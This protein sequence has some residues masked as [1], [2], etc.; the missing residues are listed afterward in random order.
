MVPLLRLHGGDKSGATN[1]LSLLPSHEHL[2]G[3][4]T[5]HAL[6]AQAAQAA[7]AA[8][9]LSLARATRGTIHTLF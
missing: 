3:G 9:S 1:A 4:A 7:Q 2:P 5:A 6:L 8:P